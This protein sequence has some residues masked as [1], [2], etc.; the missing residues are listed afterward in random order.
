VPIP[1]G[2]GPDIVFDSCSVVVLAYEVGSPIYS[3]AEIQQA[4][5]NVLISPDYAARMSPVSPDVIDDNTTPVTF[6][7]AIY[8]EGVMADTYGINLAFAGPSGWTQEYTTVNGTFP[9]GHIDSVQV[10]SGDT[11]FIS[12]TIIPNGI[13]GYGISDLHFLSGNNPST[14]GSALFR[15]VTTTGTDILVADAEENDYETSLTNCLDNIYNGVYGVVS[16]TAFHDTSVNL[17]NFNIITWSSAQSLP[18]FYPAEV[19]LLESYLDNGGR[20]FISG[21]VIGSD[22]FEP[23]GQSQFTQSFYNNYLHADYLNNSISSFQ[24]KGYAGDPITDGIE[25]FVTFIPGLSFDLIAP[26][27]VSATPILKFM[28]GPNIGAIKASTGIYRIVYS[29]MDFEQIPDEAVRD[30]IMARSIK[31]L[32]VNFTGIE[33]ENTLPLIFTL[34]QNYP[35]PFNP[36]THIKYTIAEQSNV[37]LKIYNNL[38][39]EIRS[40]VNNLTQMAILYSIYWDGKDN[41]GKMVTSGVYFYKLVSKSST[42]VFEQSRKMLLIK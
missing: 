5:Q 32:N 42:K 8:N 19:Y 3:N 41:S 14:A 10:N 31:W 29:E 36:G 17:D 9:A 6:D 7:V 30:S 38:G 25:F 28:N 23:G 34:Q 1:T 12:V 20:L 26:Y 24:I 22:I 2:G 33:S 35:N 16:R 40:L 18:A 15:N 11:T 37:Q 13:D 21:Q 27:D 4:I 39:Q